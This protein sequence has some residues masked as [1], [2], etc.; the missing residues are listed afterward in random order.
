M[1]GWLILVLSLRLNCCV[2]GDCLS[3][4]ILTMNVFIANISEVQENEQA[5]DVIP[6]HPN[7]NASSFML[8]ESST[9]KYQSMNVVSQLSQKFSYVVYI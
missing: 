7:C 1:F 4:Q 5:K 9:K 2:Y 3:P 6:Q 8:R